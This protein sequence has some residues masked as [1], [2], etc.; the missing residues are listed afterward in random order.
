[1]KIGLTEARIQVSIFS[2][3]NIDIW[4]KKWVNLS[5]H[6]LVSKLA[7]NACEPL[8]IKLLQSI[9]FCLSHK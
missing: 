1:M 8:E 4:L 6:N 2:E 5:K 3:R 7:L 9:N